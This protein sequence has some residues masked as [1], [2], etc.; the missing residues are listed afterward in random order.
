[1]MAAFHNFSIFL[2]LEAKL[3]KSLMVIVGVDKHLED[4][5]HKTQVLKGVSYHSNIWEFH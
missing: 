3:H 2:G 4:Q 5:H 1:M